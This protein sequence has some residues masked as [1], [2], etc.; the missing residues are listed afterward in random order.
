[1]DELLQLIIEFDKLNQKACELFDAY[2]RN[3]ATQQ[4]TDENCTPSTFLTPEEQ[5]RLQ[6]LNHRIT[7][8]Q[9]RSRGIQC[10]TDYRKLVALHRQL[11][12][13]HITF[14]KNASIEELTH[15]LT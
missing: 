11:T 4:L 6:D 2:W 5:S 9:E 12:L 14:S 10:P 3:N 13:A 15:H 1:M 7:V 8:L